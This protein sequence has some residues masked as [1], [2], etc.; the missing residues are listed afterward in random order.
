[1]EE[2]KILVIE[3]EPFIRKSIVSFLELE[4]YSVVSAST[5]RKAIDYINMNRFDLVITDIMLPYSGGFE[6]V[7]YLKSDPLR[8]I[9]PVVI[10]TGMD[11]DILKATKSRAD[12]CLNKPF[13]PKELIDTVK[14]IFES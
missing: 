12:Y 4:H 1:M 2:K 3:D 7:E 6:I 14:K 10:L 5:V 13:S 9:T 11:R 8:A